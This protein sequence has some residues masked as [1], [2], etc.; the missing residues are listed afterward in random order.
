MIALV[1]SSIIISCNSKEV[2]GEYKVT[3][4]FEDGS[5]LEHVFEAESKEE[6]IVLIDEYIYEGYVEEDSIDEPVAILINQ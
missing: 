3:L 1:L 4:I 2:T 6:L 5:K